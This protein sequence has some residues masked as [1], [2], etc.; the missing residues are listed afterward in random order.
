MAF[1]TAVNSQITDAL[2][3]T[4]TLS[5]SPAPGSVAE[6]TLKQVILMHGEQIAFHYYMINFICN[7]DAGKTTEI[8]EFIAKSANEFLATSTGGSK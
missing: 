3:K 4:Q 8:M 2:S 7:G 1:P 6:E 5:G